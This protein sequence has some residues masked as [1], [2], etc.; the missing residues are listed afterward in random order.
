[1]NGTAW[2]LV[3]SGWANIR[4]RQQYDC[5]VSIESERQLNQTYIYSRESGSDFT[6]VFGQFIEVDEPEWYGGDGP[7]CS[8]TPRLVYGIQCTGS[9]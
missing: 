8:H 1:M 9:I 7:S 2:N 4:A 5:Y 6:Q 3:L